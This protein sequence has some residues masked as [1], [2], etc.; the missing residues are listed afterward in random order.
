MCRDSGPPYY[1]N[2]NT[3]VVQ[4]EV[5]EQP[6]LPTQSLDGSSNDYLTPA[7]LPATRPAAIAHSGSL[8]QA[9][10]IQEAIARKQADEK[11]A[12]AERQVMFHADIQQA[13]NSA[14]QAILD[15]STSAADPTS[16]PP[17]LP[18]GPL[19]S[20]AIT[21]PGPSTAFSPPSSAS[22]GGSSSNGSRSTVA[23]L[24]SRFLSLG[25][26]RTEAPS[27]RLRILRPLNSN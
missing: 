27:C 24:I 11:Q 12:L 15:D 25:R 9:R 22:Y 7:A 14:V 21:P 19:V 8:Q 4:W 1:F 23:A 18:P 17:G 26:A 5:P 10:A 2:I 3:N 13:A 20:L 16:A 6:Q